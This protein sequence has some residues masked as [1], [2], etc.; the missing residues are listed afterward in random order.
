MRNL[1]S[2][3]GLILL[4]A[5]CSSP[6]L[7]VARQEGD[8]IP[9]MGKAPADGT[10]GLFLAGQSEDLYDL[11]L[12]SGDPLGFERGEDGVIRWLYAVG[13]NSKNRLN[14]TQTYEW[15]KLP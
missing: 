7:L 2:I 9:K 12:K 5:G 15:R 13:G 10:Y 4:L 1:L 6:G 14:V 8:A 3:A 11:P